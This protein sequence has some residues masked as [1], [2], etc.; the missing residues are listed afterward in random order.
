MNSRE[1]A[2]AALDEALTVGELLAD[3]VFVGGRSGGRPA[4]PG[5]GPI[6]AV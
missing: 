4:R 6:S 5:T 1:T 2:M 3:E